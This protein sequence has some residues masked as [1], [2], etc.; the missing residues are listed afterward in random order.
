MR[1]N[2]CLEATTAELM[3]AGVPY[4]VERGRHLKVCFHYNGRSQTVTVSR[5]ASNRNAGARARSLVRRILTA[6]AFHQST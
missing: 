6:A 3:A 1:R 2:D 4:R 5:T